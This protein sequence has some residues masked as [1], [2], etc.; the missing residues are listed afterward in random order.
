M[1]GK[2]NYVELHNYDEIIF[3]ANTINPHII[4]LY[5]KKKILFYYIILI[6]IIAAVEKIT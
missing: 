2:K 5:D 4:R 3:L 1:N 6:I